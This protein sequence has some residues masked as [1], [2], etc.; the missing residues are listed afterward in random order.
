[1]KYDSVSQAYGSQL[2][3]QVAQN[4][5]G[6]GNSSRNSRYQRNEGFKAS[7]D[8]EDNYDS[9]LRGENLNLNLNGQ[10]NI[11]NN[12]ETPFSPK[13]QREPLNNYNGNNENVQNKNMEQSSKHTISPPIT[14]LQSAQPIYSHFREEPICEIIRN[15]KNE[16]SKEY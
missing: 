14:H 13:D 16:I 4:Y 8:G 6:D 2:K 15:E 5:K 7:E 10:G 11:I 3:R 9:D 12:Q 1:M